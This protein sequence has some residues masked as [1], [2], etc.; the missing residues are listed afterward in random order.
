MKNLGLIMI[1][2]VLASCTQET[3]QQKVDLK[4]EE[5]IIRSISMK[6]L[7]AAKNHENESVS[8]LFMEN[9][10]VYRENQEPTVGIDA[11]KSLFTKDFEQNPKVVVNWVT[12]HVEIATSGDFAVE[13]GSWNDT[14][15]GLD[16]TGSDHGRYV[17]VYQKVNGVWK[18][19]SDFSLSTVAEEPPK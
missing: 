6:W 2:L 5:Q 3:A 16:G 1:F 10:V 17:T 4:A 7:E 15:R 9:G 12:E 11:I 13:Y 14:G 19:S 18:I 8:S